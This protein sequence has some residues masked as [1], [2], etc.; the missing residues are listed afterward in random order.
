MRIAK[1]GIHQHIN[2]KKARTKCHNPYLFC[3]DVYMELQ[4]FP[5]G[6]LKIKRKETQINV[7]NKDKS[8]EIHISESIIKNSDCEKLLDIKIDSKLQF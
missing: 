3:L 6:F 2:K 8:S 5:N 4:D 1:L 7:I